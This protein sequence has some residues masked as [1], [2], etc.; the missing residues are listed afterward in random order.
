MV[1][2]QIDERRRRAPTGVADAGDRR[3][4]VETSA[5]VVA[6]QDVGSPVGHIEI[7]IAV[8]VVVADRHPHAIAPIRGVPRIPGRLE[9]TPTVVEIKL[10]SGRL[11]LPVWESALHEVGI[12]VAVV[13]DVGKRHPA[14][15]D[16]RG[17]EPTLGTGDVPERD[18]PAARFVREPDPVGPGF[19]GTAGR[20]KR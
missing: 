9:A 13:V 1:T 5:A 20:K 19:L 18:P 2:V 7:H 14:A 15:H 11:G 16:L 6:E 3:H 4:I 17:P 8:V 10:V 12:E